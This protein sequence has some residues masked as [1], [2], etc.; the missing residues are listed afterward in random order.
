MISERKNE[1]DRLPDFRQ[2]EHIR[3]PK[4]VIEREIRFLSGERPCQRHCCM[5]N[6]LEVKQLA[7]FNE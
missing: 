1:D 2:C 6:C 3:L 7:T 4:P 5:D